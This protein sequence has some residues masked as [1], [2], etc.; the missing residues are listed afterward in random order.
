VLAICRETSRDAKSTALASGAQQTGSQS[1]LPHVIPV[2]VSSW[3]VSQH[4]VTAQESMKA[5]DALYFSAK[6]PKE[7]SETLT[8]GHAP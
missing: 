8:P 7:V 6:K 1:Q 3:V 4:A 2:V 5:Q